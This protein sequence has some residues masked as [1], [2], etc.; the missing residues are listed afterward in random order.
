MTAVNGIARSAERT[1]PQVAPERLL[2]GV[3]FR[4][5]SLAAA[6]WAAAH[7]GKCA[8]ELAHV[9]PI[10]DVPV[11]LRP[12]MHP[13]DD[14]LRTAAASSLPALRGFAGT[15]GARDLSVQ[16]RVGSPVD[17]LAEAAATFGAELVVLGRKAL[18]GSRGRTLER[19][20]RRLTVP[21]LVTDCRVREPPRRILAAVD[22]AAIGRNV[23]GWA[24]TLARHFGA[25]PTL[26]HVLSESLL[27]HRWL[28]EEGAR[29]SGS[30][31][32]GKSYRWVAPT[33]AWLQR[34]SD[35]FGKWPGGRTAVA[36]GS[37]GPVILE[38]ALV[39]RADLIVVGRNGAHAMS[40]ADM[41]SATRLTLRAARVPVLVVPVTDTLGLR[42]G[43]RG[44]DRRGDGVRS[45]QA[46]DALKSSLRLTA[47]EAT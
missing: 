45:S 2:V 9:L 42:H 18:D 40:T 28:W 1:S 32:L 20:I 29:E 38:R 23:V 15:L 26:L 16:V 12:S 4:Q 34:L 31:S 13:L 17:G 19:L 37:P 11:F 21:A 10:P 43:E 6:T 47:M 3:D 24:A 44:A 7:F 8:I 5:P 25:E 27:A 36:V 39:N 41:G 33:H 30:V 14:R 35:D 22:E 46:L